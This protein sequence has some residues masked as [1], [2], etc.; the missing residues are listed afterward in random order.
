MLQS[1]SDHFRL[2]NQQTEVCS[3]A[4]KDLGLLV[5]WTSLK[6]PTLSCDVA[7]KDESSR[8]RAI[9]GDDAFRLVLPHHRTIFT[10]IHRLEISQSID[11]IAPSF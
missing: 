7:Y 11:A 1:H 4:V 9:F 6:A 10:T 8:F 2:A 3:K 5:E